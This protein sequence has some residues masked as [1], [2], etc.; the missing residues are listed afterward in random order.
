MTDPIKLLIKD[1]TGQPTEI[2]VTPLDVETWQTAY[3]NVDVP[4]TLQQIKAWLHSNPDQRWKVKG[5][6]RAV[7]TWLNKESEKQSNKAASQERYKKD[8]P[9]LRRPSNDMIPDYGNYIRHQELAWRMVEAFWDNREFVAP[10]HLRN[11]RTHFRLSRTIRMIV[12]EFK[13]DPELHIGH[14]YGH[15][16]MQLRR[17]W[18]EMH[19]QAA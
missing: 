15:V 10:S 13:A 5:W 8:E 18:A 19:G 1:S 3:P 2:E 7:N 12:D 14:V 17:K 11:Y 16:N 4:Q 9:T 6:R